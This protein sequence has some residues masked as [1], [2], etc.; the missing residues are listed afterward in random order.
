MDNH[1]WSLG[2]GF[3][4]YGLESSS[5]QLLTPGGENVYLRRNTAPHPVSQPPSQALRG[6]LQA[7]GSG[8]HHFCRKVRGG[9]EKG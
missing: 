4:L 5:Y 3:L 6:V 7:T 8:V 2:G 9:Q 1:L